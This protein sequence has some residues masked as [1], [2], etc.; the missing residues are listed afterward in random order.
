MQQP[1]DSTHGHIVCARRL[2]GLTLAEVAYPPGQRTPPRSQARAC[3]V[4]VL[5]GGFTDV[6]RGVTRVCPASTL[7]FRPAGELHAGH[8][9][10]RG[11]TCLV[12]EMDEAWLAR[13]RKEGG[14]LDRSARFQGGLLLHLAHR[15]HG[16]FRMRDEVSRLLIASLVMGLLGVKRVG[17]RL[18]P[19]Y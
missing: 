5:R 8:Y 10:D 1:R 16:E 6:V 3:F 12:V 4:L 11:A 19:D 2:E 14:T 13:A 18:G 17:R 9:S 15:L 7:V